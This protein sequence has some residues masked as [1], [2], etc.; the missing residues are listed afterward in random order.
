M[1]EER[2]RGGEALGSAIVLEQRRTI[3]FERRRSRSRGEGCG[4][5]NCSM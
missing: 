1:T 3:G 2:V 5:K 4:V